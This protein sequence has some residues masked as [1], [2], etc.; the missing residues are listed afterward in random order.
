LSPRRRSSIH[1]RNI[2][3]RN[4]SDLVLKQYVWG[5]DYVDQLV[6]VAVNNDP[7]DVTE[8]DVETFYWAL[9]D[10]QYNV[11]GLVD[12]AGTMVER[13]EYTPY[14]ERSV[15]YSA[16]ADD[17]LT[18][19]PTSMSRRIELGGVEQPYGLCEIGSQGLFH[20]EETE[21]TYN[22][23]RY[24]LPRMGRFLQR[25]PLGYVDGLNLYEGLRSNPVN[26]LDPAK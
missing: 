19:S 24:R 12:D 15:Y 21:L 1:Q 17:P 23:A 11:I 14:G 6:Q 13:Y 22:N 5:V 9:H 2:E 10:A 25:D 20:D 26:L 4:G 8:D 7:T 18:M 3:T 16:G